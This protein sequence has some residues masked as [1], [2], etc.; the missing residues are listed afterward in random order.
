MRYPIPGLVCGTMRQCTVH[1]GIILPMWYRM[2]LQ[3]V[4]LMCTVLR[5]VQTT[6]LT[7]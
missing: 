7:Q 2:C 4:R 1:T 5:T 3:E 6:K